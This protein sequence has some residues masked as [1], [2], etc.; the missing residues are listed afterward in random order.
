MYTIHSIDPTRGPFLESIRVFLFISHHCHIFLTGQEETG[1]H[2]NTLTLKALKAGL[3]NSRG[4][5]GRQLTP[6]HLLAALP[7][8]V[9]GAV[10]DEIVP[11]GITHSPVETGVDLMKRKQLTFLIGNQ[12]VS[13]VRDDV[14][15]MTALII[16][17][18]AGIVTAASLCD[19]DEFLQAVRFHWSCNWI[20]LQ[21]FAVYPQILDTSLKIATKGSRGP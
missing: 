11:H 13:L 21:P 18:S 12:N 17:H 5:A 6:F 10:T 1:P 14:M 19:V 20:E 2:V 16:T 4:R 7:C 15:N 3:T 8:S 9:G